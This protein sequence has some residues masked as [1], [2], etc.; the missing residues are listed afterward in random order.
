MAGSDTSDSITRPLNYAGLALAM[1]VG[2]LGIVGI[3]L[4]SA[5]EFGEESLLKR[6]RAHHDDIVMMRRWVSEHG[7]VYVEK[8]PGVD[9]NPFLE[10]P[11]VMTTDGRVLTLRNAATVTREVSGYGGSDGTLRYRLSSLSPLNPIN[12]ANEWEAESLR[13][14]ETGVKERSIHVQEGGKS[15]FRY[16]APLAIEPSCISCHVKQG[17][18]VGGV[19]GGLSVSFDVSDSDRFVSENTIATVVSMLL[20]LFGV[21]Q[22]MVLSVRRVRDIGRAAHREQERFKSLVQTTDGIVWEADAQT[23]CFSFI[24]QRA[25]TLLGFK[26]EDWYQPGF[27]REH[28]HPEDQ[29]WAVS[30]CANATTRGEAHDFEYRFL[31]KDGRVVWLHDLVSV[32]TEDGKPTVLR[33]L[34]LDITRRKEADLQAEQMRNEQSTLLNNALVGIVYLRHRSVVMCNPRFEDL[35]GYAK[36][37]L[38]GQST[39]LLYASSADFDE[40]GEVAYATIAQGEPYSREILLR[41]KDGRVFWGVLNGRAIDPAKPHEGSIWIYADITERKHAEEEADKLLRAVERS[42]VSIVITDRD[43][44]I[45]YVNPRFT[46]VTGFSRDEVV[47]KNPRIMQSGETSPETYRQLWKT[48]LEGKEWRGVLRNRKKNGDPVWEDVSVAA[49]LNDSGATTHFVAVKEDITERLRVEEQ[50]AQYR[51]N[52]EDQVR[53]RTQDLVLAMQKATSA[54]RAKTEFLTNMSHE[55]RTPLNAIIGFCRLAMRTE[56][57][58]QQRDYLDKIDGAGQ[59]LLDL[60]NNLLD[61]SKIAAGR[62]ELLESDFDIHHL[63]SRVGSVFAYKAAEKGLALRVE[64]DPAVPR[65]LIGD[66]LRINQVLLNLINNAVKFTEHGQVDL[67]V[68]YLRGDEKCATLAFVVQDTGIGMDANELTR[69]FEPFSQ[70]DASITRK[71]GGTGLGL[72]ISRE[73]VRLMGGNLEARS[74]KGAGSQFSFTLDL[75]YPTLALGDGANHSPA[76]HVQGDAERELHFAGVRVLLVE[77][78]PLNRQVAEE[79]LRSVGVEVVMACNG[80]EGLDRLLEEGPEGFDLVFMDLQMPVMDGLSAMR[81]I[82]ARPEFA[83]LPIIAM[84]AHVLEEERRRSVAAGASDHLGKPFQPDQLFSSVANWVSPVK[85][86]RGVRKAVAPASAESA[87]G[88]SAVVDPSV[89]DWMGGL[90]RFDGKEARYITWLVRFADERADAAEEIGGLI[91]AGQLEDAGRVVHALKGVSGTLGLNRVFASSLALEHAC[92][93]GEGEA[94]EAALSTGHVQLTDAL[95]EAVTLI[96]GL[97]IGGNVGG[98]S[99]SGVRTLQGAELES[100]I[101]ALV[102]LLDML[103][104]GNGDAGEWVDV[105]INRVHGSDLEA[106]VAQIADPVARFDFVAA[107]VALKRLLHDLLD[108]SEGGKSA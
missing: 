82:R 45:E 106:D 79:L 74:E 71:Y 32:V 14:F 105:C 22:V 86:Q 26:V 94:Q 48:I 33:G 72:A 104:M 96:R 50:L 6:A 91:D 53:S 97:P 9:S 39:R 61:L 89:I 65:Q 101:D 31:A 92:K 42:P 100:L 85:V 57:T 10:S 47:G 66:S 7:G 29:D 64:V 17:Y 38:L 59:H 3:N 81:A 27:W 11:D 23:F 75:R 103:R 68:T 78:Q 99:V 107:E 44:L 73:L 49:V 8:K 51:D 76:S 98:T 84:T 55:I 18:R 4:H 70:G 52:L 69:A 41:R 88:L 43:G 25:E 1:I 40:I 34:M 62:V 5:R 2:A 19:A 13:A 67:R 46:Q 36:D 20:I 95:D 60:I 21:G 77:D 87:S 108:R 12:Q 56:L 93:Q 54:D 102:K 28:I 80:R 63:L 83:D 15:I 35:F 30:Y 90:A 58:G 24:S 37:E 16:M